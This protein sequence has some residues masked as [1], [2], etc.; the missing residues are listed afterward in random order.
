MRSTLCISQPSPSQ[1]CRTPPNTAR[2]RVAVTFISGKPCAFCLFCALRASRRCQDLTA[3]VRSIT[4]VALGGSW[5]AL[6]APWPALAPATTG[7]GHSLCITI[8]TAAGTSVWRIRMMMML[9]RWAAQVEGARGTGAS[10]NASRSSFTKPPATA[11]GNSARLLY[12]CLN[13]H[14]SLLESSCPLY[15][16]N[17]LLCMQI[18]LMIITR[19]CWYFLLYCLRD[20]FAFFY[21]WQPYRTQFLSI[22]NWG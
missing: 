12:R 2:S 22:Y 1:T 18:H 10:G 11:W 13:N 6:S 3:A 21:G 7:S 16:S 4:A 9:R 8:T 5:P 17:S 14:C 19:K 20:V 15:N